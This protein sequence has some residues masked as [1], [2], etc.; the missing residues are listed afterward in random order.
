MAR[1]FHTA[2]DI[3]ADVATVRDTDGW[4]ATRTDDGRWRFLSD[5][6]GNEFPE[7][8]SRWQ[9]MDKWGFPVTEVES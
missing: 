5:M 6:D 2:A 4:V 9:W 8:A 7:T 3:P 1:I